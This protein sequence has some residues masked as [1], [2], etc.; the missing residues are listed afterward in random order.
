VFPWSMIMQHSAP[1]WGCLWVSTW[2]PCVAERLFACYLS[3]NLWGSVRY[4]M[5]K[6]AQTEPQV[7]QTS[8]YLEYS[9][10]IENLP[11]HLEFSWISFSG[12]KMSTLAYIHR[13]YNIW[14]NFNLEYMNNIIFILSCLYLLKLVLCTE[15]NLRRFKFL[16]V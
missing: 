9:F 8:L 10:R 16:F 3:A 4:L 12:I 1:L 6:V 15:C 13:K 2:R 7:Q 14:N 11:V 5:R